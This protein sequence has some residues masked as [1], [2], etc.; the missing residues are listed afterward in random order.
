MNTSLNKYFISGS[1]LIPFARTLNPGD[2]GYRVY[3]VIVGYN[4][5][6]HYMDYIH[7]LDDIRYDKL[8]NIKNYLIHTPSMYNIRN[9][10][11]DENYFDGWVCLDLIG[12]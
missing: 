2:I 7:I 6:R 1:E 3:K 11:D 10:I 5:D 9:I 4:C 12:G 8:G